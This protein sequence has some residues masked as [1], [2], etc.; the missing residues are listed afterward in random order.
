MK[1]KFRIRAKWPQ[2]RVVKM[3]YSGYAKIFKISWDFHDIIQ[4]FWHFREVISWNFHEI[5]KILFYFWYFN[6][7]FNKSKFGDFQKFNF[8]NFK[9]FLKFRFLFS[10]LRFVGY[11]H[12]FS[13]FWIFR[14]TQFY[15]SAS[16]HCRLL[17]FFAKFVDTERL[18]LKGNRRSYTGNFIKNGLHALLV[19][20]EID[21][22]E[23]EDLLNIVADLDPMILQ[24]LNTILWKRWVKD[25]FEPQI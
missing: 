12:F 4:Q 3:A 18:H 13:N 6:W 2:D 20:D 24:Q 23:L 25:R 5:N 14:D 16:G 10:M 19:N 17:G 11:F 1:S 21:V 15:N 8:E 9:K 7:Q 22:M